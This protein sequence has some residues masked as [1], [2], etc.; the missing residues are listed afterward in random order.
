MLSSLLRRLRKLAELEPPCENSMLEVD[1]RF[2]NLTSEPAEEKLERTS[3]EVSASED[4]E[5]R[6]LR[7]RTTSQGERF[8]D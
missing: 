7:I 2:G 4:A 1:L 8:I 3:G 5:F 6:L